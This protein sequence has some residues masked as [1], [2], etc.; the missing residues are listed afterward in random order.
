MKLLQSFLL[1]SFVYITLYS[2]WNGRYEVSAV[3]DDTLE[4]EEVPE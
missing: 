4:N 3:E 1:I 2:S